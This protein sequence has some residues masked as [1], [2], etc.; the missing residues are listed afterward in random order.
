MSDNSEDRQG[1]RAGQEFV[2]EAG[3]TLYDSLRQGDLI[4]TVQLE[5]Q[6]SRMIADVSDHQLRQAVVSG[7]MRYLAEERRS[8]KTG[9]QI[10]ETI[11]AKQVL[12][13][14]SIFDVQSNGKND[15]VD[16]LLSTQAELARMP[17]GD[18]L[19][20]SFCNDLCVLSL[21]DEDSLKRWWNDERSIATEELRRVRERTAPV[22]EVLESGSEEDE[23]DED[24]ESSGSEED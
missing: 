22:I 19:L 18:G 21:F 17:G 7:L 4:D 16:F 2:K 13:K 20:A 5:L 10:R 15:E 9:S 24:E 23:D 11:S 12:I 8:G 3:N 1:P 6:N 14:K